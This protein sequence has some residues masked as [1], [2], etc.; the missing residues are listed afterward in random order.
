M[1]D[2]PQQQQQHVARV[3]RARNAFEVLELAVREH[4]KADVKRCVEGGVVGRFVRLGVWWL[5]S[6]RRPRCV[7]RGNLEAC[8]LPLRPHTAPTTGRTGGWPCFSTRTRTRTKV[9]FCDAVVL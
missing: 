1:A 6:S 4:G 7:S 9:L 2:A 3:L 8:S 5:A